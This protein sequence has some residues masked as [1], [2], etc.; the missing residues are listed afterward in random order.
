MILRPDQEKVVSDC[1]DAI[2]DGHRL[3]LV[4]APTGFGK[5]I[6]L[7][8]M[9]YAHIDRSPSNAVLILVPLID[10][11][12]QTV[13]KLRAC[14]VEQVRVLQ[15]DCDEGDSD[16]RVTVATI[17][18]VRARGERPHAT[19]VIIDEAKHAVSESYLA[20]LSGYPQAIVVGFDASPARVDGKGLGAAFDTI[21]VGPTV[22]QLVALWRAT[23]GS[24]GLVPL[25][26]TIRPEAP[27]T[28]LAQHPHEAYLQHA[29]GRRAIIFA[30][31]VKSA[32]EYTAKL[33]EA[34]VPCETVVA[35]TRGRRETYDRFGRGET[36]VLSSV[37][38]LREGF[39]SPAAEVAILARGCSQSGFIQMVGRVLRSAPGKTGA[40]LLDLKGMSHLL[41]EPDEDRVYSLEGKA[42][43]RGADE[44]AEP[45]CAVCGAPKL[46][47]VC[48]ECGFFSEQKVA[49]VVLK[50]IDRYARMKI[51][52]DAERVRIMASLI[53]KCRRNGWKLGRAFGGYRAMYGIPVSDT[54]LKEAFAV[55]N[56]RG[57]A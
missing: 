1:R 29:R 44:P 34:G 6:V 30:Q 37:G 43:R 19:M 28:A 26:P 18:T 23:G 27:T 3:I 25:E 9:A 51:H 12:H 13:S 31:N 21:V 8:K 40:L 53:A 20:L 16:A 55:A 22:R 11:A 36:L 10:L 54:I 45:C 39:D 35:S 33:L 2:R 52:G 57:A 15:G 49:K 24:S 32:N 17:D 48:A 47:D 5:T 4:V 14:G 56:V 38:V 50:P 41:G 7:S 42:I 46:N